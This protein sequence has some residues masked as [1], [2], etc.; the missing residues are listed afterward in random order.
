MQHLSISTVTPIKFSWK[1]EKIITIC[2]CKLHSSPGFNSPVSGDSWNGGSTNHLNPVCS[3]LEKKHAF[4]GFK[5]QHFLCTLFI[6]Q[7]IF[8]HALP[9]ITKE[10]AGL[11]AVLDSTGQQHHRVWYLQ[12][13]MRNHGSQR[14]VECAFLTLELY[15][16]CVLT[17]E[18]EGQER[19]IS[20]N[21]VMHLISLITC[22]KC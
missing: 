22:C 11:G 5:I 2:Q 17:L 15:S 1:N 3:L 9:G 13:M 16:V 19:R 20:A 6:T 12:G 10:E 21:I 18:R 4:T 8:S 7:I 14:H